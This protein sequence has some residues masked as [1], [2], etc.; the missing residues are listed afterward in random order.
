MRLAFLTHATVADGRLDGSEKSYWR[1][2]RQRRDGRYFI[3]IWHSGTPQ[4]IIDALPGG[5]EY[6]LS[7]DDDQIVI[8]IDQKTLPLLTDLAVDVSV[9]L[10]LDKYRLSKVSERY[11]NLL[12][13]IIILA[14]FVAA[15]IIGEVTRKGPM[16]GIA[17]LI[18]FFS[19]LFIYGLEEV[20]A[21][22]V[23]R[24]TRVIYSAFC[25][26]WIGAF[27]YI[28]LFLLSRLF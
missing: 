13:F 19:A 28:G 22:E 6:F 4:K 7:E 24:L 25:G 3:S 21:A 15:V 26:W 2:Y 20:Q 18:G 1:L 27:A 14:F 17:V 8:E 9:D 10:D 12:F 5:S 23:T 16:V 11:W